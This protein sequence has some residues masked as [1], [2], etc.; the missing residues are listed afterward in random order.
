MAITLTGT[1]GLFTI[2]GK[3]FYAGDVVNTFRGTSLPTENEDAIETADG[4]LDLLRNTITPDLLRGE[5]SGQSGLDS[6]MQAVRRASEQLVVYM[7]DADKPLASRTVE[8]A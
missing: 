6:Y 1:R 3:I 2:L 7:A 4:G 5:E 8:A